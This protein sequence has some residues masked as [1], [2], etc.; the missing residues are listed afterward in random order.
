M[1]GV[2]ELEPGTELDA[3]FA[4]RWTII[5]SIAGFAVLSNQ[6]M[7]LSPSPMNFAMPSKS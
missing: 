6:D 2:P 7:A 3:S 4:N 5:A 1:S